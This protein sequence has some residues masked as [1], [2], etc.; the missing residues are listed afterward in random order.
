[1]KALLVTCISILFISFSSFGQNLLK[2]R[3][4]SYHTLIY[5][6]TDKEAWKINHQ[7]KWVVDSSFFH[8][9]VDSYPTDST[10]TRI[11]P[12]GHYLQIY[13]EGN[14]LKMRYTSVQDFG[15]QI[16][17]NS[18]DLNVAVYTNKGDVIEDA[19]VTL[20]GS[21]LK[22]DRKTRTYRKRKTNR[23]GLLKVSFQGN[24]MYY[25]LE[26][27]L[28]N[29]IVKRA[30]RK[31][32]YGTPLNYIWIPIRFVVLIPVD[33]VKSIS[34]G[35]PQG[36]INR[37]A[38]KSKNL[39]EK[40]AC[41]FD[42]YYCDDWRFKNKH[43]GYVGFS[44]PVYRPNDTVSFKVFLTNKRGKPINKEV[45]VELYKS[46]KSISFG[47]ISPYDRG[48]YTFDFFLSDTLDLQLDRY[49]SVS[50]LN[51][52]G[53]EYISSSFK[54]EEYELSKLSL[55]VEAVKQVHY[56]GDS[57][58]LTVNA[59][60]D[61]DLNVLDG[62]LEI[63]IKPKNITDYFAKQVFVSD[64]L[65]YYEKA[66]DPNGD[67]QIT[68]SDTFLPK[69][70]M[71]YE[72]SVNLLT[73]DNERLSE[74]IP[75]T[76]CFEKQEVKHKLDRDSIHLFFQKNGKTQNTNSL[77][78][79]YDAHDNLV[80]TITKE[81]PCDLPI[82]PYYKKMVVEID[83]ASFL[84]EIE[85]ESSL[86]GFQAVRTSDSLFISTQNPR[87]IPFVYY[88]YKTNNEILRGNGKELEIKRKVTTDQNH[89][90]SVQ[91]L[92]S[93][94]VVEENFEINYNKNDLI[95]EVESPSVVYPGQEVT[96]AVNVKDAMGDP[97]SNA[98]VLAHG[99]T[100]KFNHGM[101]DLPNYSKKK[102]QRELIN[103]F[104]AS[105]NPNYQKSR[106]INYDKWNPLM[107]LD[108]I[109][110]YQFLYP[111]EQYRYE[112]TPSDSM[113]QISPFVVHDG[114]IEPI[115]VVYIDRNPVY[116]SWTS[117]EPY[118]FAI[119]SG[120]HKI[121]IRT[122]DHLYTFPKVYVGHG[123]K[124]IVSFNHDRLPKNGRV[125]KRTYQFTDYERSRLTRYVMSYRNTFNGNYGYLRQN[126]R[127]HK[128]GNSSTSNR[129]GPVYSQYA[130][131]HLF[132][133]FTQSF[134]YESFYNYEFKRGLI[135]MRSVEPESLMPK[136]TT[137]GHVFSFDDE[138]N[139]K[140]K[141][142]EEWKSELKYRRLQSRR[143]D[144]PTQTK[145]GRGKLKILLSKRD[146]EKQIVNAFLFHYADSDFI[147]IYPN[148]NSVFHDLDKGYYRLIY[149]NEDQTYM[150]VD[151]IEVMA[152]GINAL[153]VD[154][155]V[156]KTEDSF[157]KKLNQQ[158]N[159]YFLSDWLLP[160]NQ[161]E[162]E[163]V[164]KTYQQQYQY[165]GPGEVISG[166]VY[167]NEGEGLPGVTILI[168]GT[169]FGTVTDMDGFYSL[170]VPLNS[171]SLE[172]SFIGYMTHIKN[173]GELQT[174]DVYLEADVQALEEVVV[175]GYGT[176]RKRRVTGA[177][178][179]VSVNRLAGKMAGVSIA[180]RGVSSIDGESKPLYVV[181]GVPYL[182]DLDDLEESE[183]AETSILKDAAAVAIYGS[184]AVGGVI[185]I[186]TKKGSKNI[187]NI[188]PEESLI[189]DPVFQSASSSNSIRSN[190]SDIS[191]WEP[192]LKTD[193]SGQATFTVKFPDD[194]T[195]WD[196]F[197]YV[198]GEKRRSGKAQ[199]FT[200]SFKP[201]AAQLALPRFILEGDSTYA[202]GKVF[203]YTFD[204]V[205]VNTSLE[206]NN[207]LIESNLITLKES[208][209]DTLLVTTSLLDSVEL[210]YYLDRED[211]YFDG[212]QRRLPVYRVGVEKSVGNYTALMGDTTVMW[213]F[214]DSLG[215][216]Y[217]KAQTKSV[218]L[219]RDKIEYLIDYP[220][221]CNEQLASK[222][223]ALLVSRNLDDDLK[224][225]EARNGQIK[226]VI[227]KLIGNQNKDGLWGWW[228]QSM[229]Q[230][231]IS[232]HVVEA[233]EMAQNRGYK[234]PLN[235]AIISDEA[236]WN[237]T[238]GEEIEKRIEWLYISS[239]LGLE[240]KN[241]RFVAD[242]KGL[243]KTLSAK[244][245]IAKIE[246][247]N[248]QPTDL[249][250]LLDSLKEDYLNNIHLQGKKEKRCFYA[251]QSLLL[252][253]E[254]L[255]VLNGDSTIA[256][257]VKESIES[258]IIGELGSNRFINTYTTS[259][260]ISVLVSSLKSSQS[261]F[262]T[263]LKIDGVTVDMSEDLVFMN[264]YD[265]KESLLISKKGRMPI[266]INAYQKYWEE[267]PAYDSS[268][269]KITSRFKF[270]GLELE[271]GKP[272]KIFVEVTLDNDA[273]YVMIEIPIP[274]GC[275]YS[276]K[277]N[278][279]GN[280]SYRE[281]HKEKVSIFCGKIS[282]GKHRFEVELLPRYQGKYTLNPAKIELMYFPSI[283]SHEG[284]KRVEIN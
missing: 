24:I 186:T 176:D 76:Y 110:Y 213:D 49:Y 60:D 156:A 51:K 44:K 42:D 136:Y 103:T 77:I 99:M 253:I 19:L 145:S 66:L 138:V 160:L 194:I 26:R 281:Y 283:H 69:V 169:T 250:W 107:V 280:E 195:G 33:G 179:G 111:K 21:K 268:S 102:K 118:S 36:V 266:Y 275:S 83:S 251:D 212:E 260:A 126:N 139:T 189:Q 188:S 81:L 129:I 170:K 269:F 243:A 148:N 278:Y 210:K 248:D 259:R 96:L 206:Q 67:T 162:K 165:F 142:D 50:L 55:D 227:K 114:N 158:M 137:S 277:K 91:Y 25:Q 252:T 207:R 192:S 163:R 284:V 233:L 18:R 274:A 68:I 208:H 234:V 230:M 146:N 48:G 151:S 240:I 9:L 82:N 202:I 249:G 20:G 113:T 115:N 282:Q 6:L 228:N 190:F 204:S 254:A 221:G 100:R 90:L 247:L 222:L 238:S 30:S 182:G 168:K 31:L 80:E 65:N 263:K 256:P 85:E 203:N 105:S 11:L 184:R 56:R 8:T 236:I 124:L 119:D 245:K 200:K 267:N 95:V 120:Y 10:H 144:N 40:V 22:F 199:S 167:D 239:V 4:S 180:I 92:W 41:M 143:Y 209:I 155:L 28:N 74:T 131:F 149:L 183:I 134:N 59:K 255:E 62:R 71:E 108:S 241:S 133:Q 35:Y 150:E 279:Y 73:S 16:L 261:S 47:K 181:D 205:R 2:D 211:G 132:D 157:S 196:T 166:H 258:Y 72:L 141:L 106:K 86:L 58:T 75:M 79:S 46:V 127:F 161:A 220:Y 140:E 104:G 94:R 262:D 270:E 198:M 246:Q 187:S 174:S 257:T 39:F 171:K 273:E 116:F 17:N 117:K 217:L 231:W 7:R 27:D 244:L 53:K 265:A 78:R 237:L 135:K 57:I 152:N 1:M 147:R 173:L 32:I 185:L 276:D 226:R 23:K 88:L 214:N 272:E 29:S 3:I 63:L 215:P 52:K 219:L 225:K 38:W 101:I 98:D 54:Y 164:F 45:E 43:N 84:I 70:N 87:K 154:G 123:K 15:I 224:I 264:E 153:E 93:G 125:E 130:N 193:K 121:E 201:F 197:V 12:N 89:Y 109:A 223:K 175:V 271:S 232:R 191:F 5:R 37:L 229:T 13:S 34:Y 97:V 14:Q 177:V 64:T 216:V 242:L 218:E 122:T 128:V 172:Y 61:N 178:A 159:A 235:K 112:Y